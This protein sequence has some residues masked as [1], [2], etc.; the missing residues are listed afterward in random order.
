MSLAVPIHI[1]HSHVWFFTSSSFF[2]RS[3]RSTENRLEFNHDMVHEH[4]HGC[5]C[6]SVAV[7]L[8]AGLAIGFARCACRVRVKIGMKFRKFVKDKCTYTHRKRTQL[9][10][11][12][13]VKNASLL[14]GFGLC[15]DSRDWGIKYVEPGTVADRLGTGAYSRISF[16]FSSRT[17]SLSALS[18]FLPSALCLALFPL[19]ISLSC[20]LV[21]SP[22]CR[23]VRW[24]FRSL[25]LSL[26]LSLSLSPTLSLPLFAPRL[27]C[28][29]QV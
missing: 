26:P 5:V 2:C 29:K 9:Y 19:L 4:A 7:I 10:A 1:W 11:H 23:L 21:L 6:L 27:C 12:M 8:P 20:P 22:N 28:I 18:L 14:S 13:Q 25:F 17:L 3:Q 15:V 16:K 24:L